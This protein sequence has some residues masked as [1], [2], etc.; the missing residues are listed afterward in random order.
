M[1][2]KIFQDSKPLGSKKSDFKAISFGWLIRKSTLSSLS[3]ENKT[4]GFL[5]L[6]GVSRKCC[7]CKQVFRIL[8][9]T[10][11]DVSPSPR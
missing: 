1:A 8:A 11:V 5:R 9:S 10:D 4:D 6:E 7:H 2:K 3:G